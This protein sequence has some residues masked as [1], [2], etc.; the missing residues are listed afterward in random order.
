MIDDFINKLSTYYRTFPNVE[1]MYADTFRE[2]AIT[3][4]NLRLY[5]KKMYELKPEYL[6]VGEAPGYKGCRW[7]GVPFTSER[8]IKENNFFGL[9]NGYK[10]RNQDNP[11]SESS[12]TIVWNCL[13]KLNVKPLI[14]NAFPFHPHN[15]GETNSN[16]A[17]TSEELKVGKIILEELIEIFNIEQNHIIPVGRNAEKNLKGYKIV[18]CL[19]HPSHGGKYEFIRGMERIFNI[20]L[21]QDYL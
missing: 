5:L 1:N 20:T 8:N 15:E 11:E 16:R 14:W 4:N 6:I 19:R 7:S 21:S 13:D 9:K 2:S 12:A 18:T 10:I 17:P 3:K